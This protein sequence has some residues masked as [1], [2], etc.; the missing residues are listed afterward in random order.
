[1]AFAAL[2]GLVLSAVIQTRSRLSNW[3][4]EYPLLV[5]NEGSG[6][7]PWR[8]RL[9][10][11]EMTDRATP[12]A[13]LREF[14]RGAAVQLPGR[15]VAVF[16]F[17]DGPPYKD[18]SGTLPPL[19]WT[20]GRADDD[21]LDAPGNASPW[22]RTADGIAAL[23]TRLKQTNAF[24]LRVVGAASDTGQTGPARIVSNSSDP[25]HRNFTVGQEGRDLIVRVRTP[26]TGMNGSPFHLV[27]P[28]VFSTMEIR[29]IVVTYDGSTVA[30]AARKN[31]IARAELTP[32]AILAVAAMG[33]SVRAQDAQLYTAAYLAVLF[34]LPMSVVGLFGRDLQER[35]VLAGIYVIGFSPM[36]EAALAGTIGRALHV[37]SVVM[38]L[39][40]G[41]VVSSAAMLVLSPDFEWKRRNAASL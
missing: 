27:V 19:Q 38:T 37:R 7:R 40:V 6:D 9:V 26:A 28:D 2:A 15:P 4:T 17:S 11:V 30:A 33:Y 3:S 18:E 35:L 1:M 22:L 24:S 23:A 12:F 14:E 10:S 31:G 41:S 8:G 32:G 39:L 21:D 25:L 34:I 16:T 20:A 5:G 13:R 29:D 36:L